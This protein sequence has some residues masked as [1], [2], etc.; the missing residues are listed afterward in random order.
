MNKR[1]ASHRIFVEDPPSPLRGYGRAG[2]TEPRCQEV[3]TVCVEGNTEPREL[4]TRR[5][6]KRSEG[7]ARRVLGTAAAGAA[8]AGLKCT[9][10]GPLFRCPLLFWCDERN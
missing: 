9:P 3:R 1:R 6:A 10:A 5:N 8:G 7:F 4:G 2:N